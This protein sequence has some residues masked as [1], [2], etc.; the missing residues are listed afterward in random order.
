MWLALVSFWVVQCLLTLENRLKCL[1]VV[2]KGVRG[3]SQQHNKSKS[4]GKPGDAC[5]NPG[6]ES[7]VEV[8]YR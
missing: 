3:L 6:R 4:T 8:H 7:E 5:I 1:G 2:V